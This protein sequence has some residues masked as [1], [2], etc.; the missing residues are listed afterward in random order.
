[1]NDPD[2]LEHIYDV[3][4]GRSS[5]DEVMERL[6]AEF[7]AE[8]ALLIAYGQ[9]PGE[10]STHFR[11]GPDEGAV[12]AYAD[13]FA[14]I[15]PYVEAMGSGAFP[16]GRVMFGDDV[17]PGKS[18]CAS[19]F[20]HDWF[21]PNGLRYTAGGHVQSRDGLR[22]LLAMPRSDAAGPYVPNEVRALQGYFNHIRRALEIQDE[23][24]SRVFVPDFD[25]IAARYR[26]TPAEAR[27]LELL[28][29]TG[30]LKKSAQRAQ[31]SYNTL[32]AQLRAVLAKTETCS[33]SQLMR[34]IHRAPVD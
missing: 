24:R 26:L 13:H 16:P 9:G 21:R 18:L 5:W 29:E 30:S 12:R 14:A 7:Y 2:L 10:T 20:Y 3:V 25:R 17:V 27:L 33:Q 8:Q 4:L 6:R 32:R 28:V 11:S 19:E 23:M 1:V 31:R 15:D 34:L 22:L